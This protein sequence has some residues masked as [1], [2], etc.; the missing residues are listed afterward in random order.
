MLFQKRL[1]RYCFKLDCARLSRNK[2]SKKM[3]YARILRHTPSIGE[4]INSCCIYLFIIFI[5][6][7]LLSFCRLRPF[8][9]WARRLPSIE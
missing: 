1:Q 7:P 4:W 5:V 3:G 6:L 9:G 8:R 2:I